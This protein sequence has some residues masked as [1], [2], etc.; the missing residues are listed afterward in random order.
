M[1]AV[2]ISLGDRDRVAKLY[3]YPNQPNGTDTLEETVLHW[4]NQTLERDG[5]KDKGASASVRT[6]GEEYFLDL[7]GPSSVQ[8]DLQVYADRLPKFLDHGPSLKSG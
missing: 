6:V 3:S 7:D 8:D 2:C 4:F 5:L 1:A